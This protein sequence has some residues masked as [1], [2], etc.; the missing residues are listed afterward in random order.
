MKAI[1]YA[2]QI[3]PTR[4]MKKFKDLHS[5]KISNSFLNRFSQNN[6]VEG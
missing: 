6:P 4:Q 2:F 3:S 1:D 5:R